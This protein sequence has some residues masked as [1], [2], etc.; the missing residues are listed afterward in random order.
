MTDMKYLFEPKSIAVIGASGDPSKIGYRVVENII[1]GGYNGLLYPVNPR[2]GE[3]LGHAVA[4]SLDDIENPIDLAC[5]VIPAPSVFNAVC[6]CAQRGV[7]IALVITS[8][9]SEIGNIEEE[10]KIISYAREHGIRILGPNVF[11]I[12]SATA[13]LNAT[14]G[15][16]DVIEGNVAIITQSGALGASMIGKTAVEN[17]GLSAMVSVGNKADID[18]SELLDYLITQ[19]QTKIIL[20]YIEGVKD[21]ERLI[22][23]LNTATK[24]KPVV[25]IKS[26]RSAKGAIAAASHTGSLAGTDEVFDAIVRQYGV[27]RA[28]DIDEA[29]DWC[30]FLSNNPMPGGEHTVI[31]TNGGGIGVMTADA[32]EKYGVKLY[33]DLPAL[34][35]IFSG[36]VPDFGSTK[37]PVDLT[38]QATTLEFEK[39]LDAALANDDIHTVITLLSEVAI[40]DSENMPKLIETYYPL[41]KEKGKPLLFSCLGGDK[42][43]KCINTYSIRGLPVYDG[44]YEGVSC[45]G[46]MYAYHDYLETQSED[47]TLADIPEG[48]IER[49]A[50][51]ALTH[52][53][54]FLLAHE[55]RAVMEAAGIPIPRSRVARTLEGAVRHADEIGYPVV[56]KVVSKDIVHKSDAGGVALDLENSV[57]VIDAYQAILHTCRA[58]NPNAV[59][60][61]VDV[62][63]MAPHGLELIIGARRDQV[64]GPIVMFGLGGV[65]VE[66]MK[67]ISFR[68]FP[69]NR[70]EIMRMIEEVRSYPL[71][72]GVRGERRRDIRGIIDTIIKLGTII[73]R[74]EAISDIEINP[75]VAYEE[76]EGVKALDVRILLLKGERLGT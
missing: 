16:G 32:C 72:L 24:K 10:N 56:I 39:A 17:I 35:A 37:N 49:I 52:D 57:E 26:G 6:Q 58:Y 41:F 73:K 34:N 27:L 25:V 12:Y 15:T 54:H 18:E 76:G 40:F 20:M 3:L 23:A 42:V 36:V 55:A 48:E 47:L 14:F 30:K 29:F 5:I 28:E 61:G 74:C 1:L 50:S 71:L 19:D 68:A 9:F 70:N 7:K 21:G 64:F 75:L 63:E 4:K 31:I 46:A 69:L 45:L 67:D 22:T 53:R 2:G 66:V 38:G 13:S 62:M 8:G 60:E 51:E 44:A 65:Y 33:D 59:I 11:G 43:Q